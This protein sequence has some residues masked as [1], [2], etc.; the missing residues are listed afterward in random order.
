[1]RIITTLFICML[2]FIRPAIAALDENL[3]NNNYGY[4]SSSPMSPGNMIFTSH[5]F[6]SNMSISYVGDELLFSFP[7]GSYRRINL[8]TNQVKDVSKLLHSRGYVEDG[9]VDRG[10]RITTH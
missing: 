5:R 3:I 8:A 2:C 6:Q 9:E 7:D 10:S 1:M 4:I